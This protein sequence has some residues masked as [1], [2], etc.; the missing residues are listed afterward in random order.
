[1]ADLWV[2]PQYTAK[3]ATG[4]ELGRIRWRRGEGRQTTRGLRRRS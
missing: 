3:R 4:V 1:V 2:A